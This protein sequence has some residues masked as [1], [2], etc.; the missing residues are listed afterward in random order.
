[1]K[2]SPSG[3]LFRSSLSIDSPLEARLSSG[4]AA[5]RPSSMK[6]RRYIAGYAP[7]RRCN[8]F[9]PG[10]GMRRENRCPDTRRWSEADWRKI[11]WTRLAGACQAA[12]PSPRKETNV[13][14]IEK[15][16]GD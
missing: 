3:S 11:V 14:E 8:P 16:R 2:G 9:E 1:M 6:R 10:T 13:G 12:A 7:A 5:V 15:A 4:V